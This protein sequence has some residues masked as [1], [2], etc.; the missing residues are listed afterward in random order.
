MCVR[1]LDGHREIELDGCR[2]KRRQATKKQQ[3]LEQKTGD[4]KAATEE[5]LAEGIETAGLTTSFQ[6]AQ[7]E[8]QQKGGKKKLNH[9]CDYDSEDDF[10]P[11]SFSRKIIQ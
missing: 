6:G 2:E 1:T 7:S 11:G 5:S 8:K 10:V 4:L 9:K 3:Q